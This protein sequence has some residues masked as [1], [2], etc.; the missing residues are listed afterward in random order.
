M[1]SNTSSGVSVRYIAAIE[2]LLIGP[3]VLF[4]SSLIVRN[5]QPTTY[6]PAQTA[7]RVVD[8]FAVH[9]LLCLD[10]F[11][12][13]LPLVALVMGFMTVLRLWREDAGLRQKAWEMLRAVR[14]HLATLLIAAATLAAGS[15]LGI[16]ALHMITG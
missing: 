9:P 15:I 1:E 3:A 11:L 2:L 16:V 4:M 6:E 5:L 12:I 10:I 13:T 7:Q 8:W 14:A